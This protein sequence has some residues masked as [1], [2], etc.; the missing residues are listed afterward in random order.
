MGFGVSGASAIIF[1]GLLI[2]GVTMYS[3]ADAT[4]E[5]VSEARDDDA[6]RL[7][8]RRNTDIDVANA[9]FVNGTDTLTIAVEN[10]GST[11]LSV[12][13]TTLLVNNTYRSLTGASV[14]GVT[15]TD[16]WEPGAVLRL[17]ASTDVWSSSRVTIVT[18]NGVSKSTDV[19][20]A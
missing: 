9:T 20:V 12:N 8:D 5:R 19:T 1:L 14:D 6:E 16:L 2:A 18:E 11:T 13:D 17:N 7:L 4:V 15:A 10:T 3:T